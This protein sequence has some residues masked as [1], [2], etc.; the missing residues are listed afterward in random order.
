MAAELSAQN[1]SRLDAKGIRPMAGDAALSALGLA[2]ASG[3]AEVAV[4]SVD[5]NALAVRGNATSS[6]ALLRELI[7]VVPQQCETSGSVLT[8][9][10]ALVDSRRRRLLVEHVRASALRVLGL[11]DGALIEAGRPLREFGVDSLAAVELRNALSRSLE[12]ALPAT[13]A[14]DYPTLNAIA[15]YL[16]RRLFPIEPKTIVEASSSSGTEAIRELSED[17]AESLLLAELETGGRES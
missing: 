8:E 10:R 6:P 2:I 13:L 3:T 1:T 7:G 9:L 11:D 14:F 12:C 15:D 17:E 5:W 16:E 4:M